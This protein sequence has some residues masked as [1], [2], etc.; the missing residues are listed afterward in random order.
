MRIHINQCNHLYGNGL[1]LLCVYDLTSPIDLSPRLERRITFLKSIVVTADFNRMPVLNSYVECNNDK[2]AQ[3]GRVELAYIFTCK[4]RP[5]TLQK[6]GHVS[7]HKQLF[8]RPRMRRTTRA[9]AHLDKI[10]ITAP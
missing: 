8:Q 7:F 2:N 4:I 10:A 5:T 1:G 9:L 3:T 6:E